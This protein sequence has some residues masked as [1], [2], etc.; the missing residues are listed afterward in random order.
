[1][2]HFVFRLAR[3]P[4][5]AYAFLGLLAIAYAVETYPKSGLFGR[6]E[7][8]FWLGIKQVEREDLIARFNIGIH[9][10][11]LDEKKALRIFG[12]ILEAKTHPLYPMWQVRIY[13]ELAMF[14]AFQKDFAKA[15]FY[16]GELSKRPGGQS[17]HSSFNYSYYL[18]FAGWR[19]EGEKVVQALVDRYPLNHL[20]LIRA[21]KFYLIVKDYPRAAELYG[22]DYRLFRNEQTRRLLEE[23]RPL[24]PPADQ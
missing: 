8:G 3:S 18:A 14:Y 12:Q 15:E 9:T 11:P 16:F 4:A 5:V 22:E 10:L 23:L 1:V 21:A 20:V 13:E 2:A 24:I 19:A 7:N 6:D 17:L